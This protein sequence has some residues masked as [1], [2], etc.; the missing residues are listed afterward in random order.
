MNKLFKY[1][2]LTVSILVFANNPMKAQ[3]YENGLI[4]KTVALVGNDMIMISQ[5]EDEIK[6]MSA[7]G[8]VTDANARCQILENMMISK[9]FLN[10]A[11]ID[12][13]T[14][15]YDFV[16]MELNSWISQ[17][18][19]YLGG[20]KGVEEYFGKSIFRIK[21]ERREALSEMSLTDD[22]RRQVAGSATQ[23]TPSQIK[24]YFKDM[25]KD[26]LPIVSPQYQYRHIVLYPDTEDAGLKAKEQLLEI[27]ERI[28]AGERFS[29]LAQ[30]YSQD[31]GTAMKGGELGMVSK[32]LYWPEFSDAAMALKAGQVSSIVET[33]D[34]FHIIQMIERDGEMFNARHILRKPI[35]TAADRDIAFKRLDSIK[36][37]IDTG[38]IEFPMA[39]RMYSRDHKSN[40]SGGVVVNEMTGSSLLA[41]DELKPQD[42]EI[43]KNMKEGD[44][45]EP[46][47]SVDNEGR[48]GNTVYKIIKLE[49]IIPSHVA[50]FDTD[51]SVLQQEANNK[52]A[53]DAIVAFIKEKQATSYIV[54]D[55]MFHQCDFEYSG[56]IK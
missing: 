16:D 50:N 5:I 31:P 15:N 7:E 52:V 38:M 51:F 22:M 36:T 47:E 37:Q 28:I 8:Y 12:S 2:V 43:I 33:P 45:S 10:Q 55:P 11:R 13:L 27:R 23:M 54:I 18:M 48:S 17:M 46:F 32:Q 6:M 29:T 42:Y 30:I 44:I 49:K 41:I 26:S 20:E 1:C 19:S 24:N 3:R 40:M 56:W 39:A 14:V 35:Y 9:L 25:P 34:G 53:M 4:D 21:Q